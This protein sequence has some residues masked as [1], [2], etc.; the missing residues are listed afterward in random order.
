MTKVISFEKF[1][2][3]KEADM[4]GTRPS[5][6]DVQVQIHSAEETLSQSLAERLK[7]STR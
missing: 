5:N 2:A 6:V 1:M 7:R 3:L 4:L